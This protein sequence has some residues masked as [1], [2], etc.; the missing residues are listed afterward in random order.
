MVK[1]GILNYMRVI[2]MGGGYVETITAEYD[3]YE[4]TD[5]VYVEYLTKQNS[6]HSVVT[7][8]GVEDMSHNEGATEYRIIP[9]ATLVKLASAFNLTYSENYFTWSTQLTQIS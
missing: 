7:L 1:H 9:E 8:N 3:V 2:D 4:K 5:G 6:F